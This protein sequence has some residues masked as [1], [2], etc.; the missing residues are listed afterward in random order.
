VNTNNVRDNTRS[1]GGEKAVDGNDTTYWATNDGITHATL[2]IDME[3]PVEI[4]AI[5]LA[6][7]AGLVPRT[8]GI[9][10]YKVEGQVNSDWKLLAAGTTIGERKVDTFPAAIVWKVR[11][12][13]IKTAGYPAIKEIGL[14]R[15]KK[16]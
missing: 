11:L 15:Q 5:T 16:S 6:E 8:R 1:F 9:Q 3:G 4:N 12:T 2:E 13:I 7:A 14:Y 10:E